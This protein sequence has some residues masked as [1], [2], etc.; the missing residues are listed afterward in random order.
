M[1]VVEFRAHEEVVPYIVADADSQMLH[2]V[3]AAGVID[4]ASTEIAARNDRRNIKA[5]RS[6]TDAAHQI[7]SSFL[8]Q[9]GLKE[10]V[11]VSQNRA[12]GFVLPGVRTL[13]SPPRSFD[14]K[15]EA[16][17]E[18]DH[19]TAEVDIRASLFGGWLKKQRRVGGGRR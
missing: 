14:I 2:E 10:S 3:I 16:A 8:A 7:E 12:I 9:F 11:E 19:V 17:L 1:V 15:T 5:G 13:A 6:H 18:S 4:T